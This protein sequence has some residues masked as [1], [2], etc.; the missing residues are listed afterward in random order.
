MALVPRSRSFVAFPVCVWILL[1][2]IFRVA[3]VLLPSP[4]FA[5]FALSA[6]NSH[7]NSGDGCDKSCRPHILFNSGAAPKVSRA[8]GACNPLRT[9]RFSTRAAAADAL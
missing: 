1:F 9:E 3:V 8:G 2:A 7:H 5:S 4:L 6:C